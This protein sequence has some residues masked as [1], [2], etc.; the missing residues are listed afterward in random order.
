MSGNI[1]LIETNC[2]SACGV[3]GWLSTTPIDL[4]IPDWVSA[5]FGIYANVEGLSAQALAAT[6]IIGSYFLAKRRRGG[7]EDRAGRGGQQQTNDHA[8]ITAAGNA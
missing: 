1:Q 4:P 3:L 8:F 5:W 2:P 6:L 7:R